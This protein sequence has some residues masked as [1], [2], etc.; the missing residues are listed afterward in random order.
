MD[1][2]T[3]SLTSRIGSIQIPFTERVSVREVRLVEWER[4]IN[5][6]AKD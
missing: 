6:H 4:E 5:F 2:V 3:M 1:E